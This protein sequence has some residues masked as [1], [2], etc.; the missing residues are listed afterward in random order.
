MDT[1]FY[2]RITQITRISG[3]IID[4]EVHE[5]KQKDKRAKNRRPPLADAIFMWI[6]ARSM[7][8]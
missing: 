6:P 2:P 5:R 1:N 3:T 7:Q 8:E 4:R